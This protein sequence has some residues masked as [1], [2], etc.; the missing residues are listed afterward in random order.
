MSTKLKK[1]YQIILSRELA[2]ARSATLQVMKPKPFSV[3]EVLIPVI[4][5]LNYMRVKEQRE[6]FTQNLIFTKKLAMDAALDMAKNNLNKSE[7]L[8]KIDNQTKAV[9]AHVDKNIYSE[10]IRQCQIDE[11]DLL[12]DHFHRLLDIN[13]E[14]YTTLI[15]NAY[16]TKNNYIAFA[17][18]LKNAEK[19]VTSAAC[20][21]LG[22]KTDTSTLANLESAIDLIRQKEADKIFGTDQ[23]QAPDVK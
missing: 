18:K 21:T 1:K 12:I 13:G 20:K 22:D 10:E 23:D 2:M 6:L 8:A 11:I 14:D 9:I 4:F 3:W 16:Q 5:I 19:K 17:N 7:A 15:I